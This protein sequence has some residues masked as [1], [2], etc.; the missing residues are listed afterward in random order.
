[1]SWREYRAIR[2]SWKEKEQK[3]NQMEKKAQIQRELDMDK[4]RRV[5]KAKAE[6]NQRDDKAAALECDKKA[7]KGK[8]TS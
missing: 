7:K 3:K 6:E 4:L 5:D 8:G 1:M 2:E